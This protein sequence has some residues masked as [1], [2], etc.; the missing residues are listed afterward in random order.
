MLCNE[1]KTVLELDEAAVDDVDDALDG[2]GRLRNVG[3]H[4]HLPAAPHGRPEHFELVGGRKGAVH[5][6]RPHLQAVLA[7]LLISEKNGSD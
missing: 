4:H 7:V 1:I 6:Q 3:G 5:W 2:D